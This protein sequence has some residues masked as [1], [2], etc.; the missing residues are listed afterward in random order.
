MKSHASLS[1]I[2]RGA[3]AL[4]GGLLLTPFAQS[5]PLGGQVSAGAGV[6][7]SAPVGDSKARVGVG[8]GTSTVIHDPDAPSR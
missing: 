8:V 5:E 2:C 6:G 1:R 7:V 4:T 3:L